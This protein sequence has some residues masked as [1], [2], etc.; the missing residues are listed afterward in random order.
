MERRAE[1]R[2]QMTEDTPVKY[3]ALV[4]GM[5]QLNR[6]GRFNGVKISRGKEDGG[7][8]VCVVN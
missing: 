2:R 6:K 4:I 7:L 1:D 8:G 5:P 3:A